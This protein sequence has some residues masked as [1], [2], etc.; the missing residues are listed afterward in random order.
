MYENSHSQTKT[1]NGTPERQPGKA[2]VFTYRLLKVKTGLK[3]GLKK[4]G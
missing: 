3:A 1:A 2:N 4:K